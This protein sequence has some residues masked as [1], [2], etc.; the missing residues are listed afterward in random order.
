MPNPIPGSWH[1]HRGHDPHV[2]RRAHGVPH[3]R[4][5]QAAPH[6][7][8]VSGET[9]LATPA[10]LLVDPEVF[11]VR[12]HRRPHTHTAAT[13]SAR[14]KMATTT[15]RT[16]PRSSKTHAKLVEVE[17]QPNFGR[18]A[19]LIAPR[20]RAAAACPRRPRPPWL[21]L[22]R[23]AMR[24]TRARAARTNGAGHSAAAALRHRSLDR[25]RTRTCADVNPVLAMLFCLCE[26]VLAVVCGIAA[27]GVALVFVL[28]LVLV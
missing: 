20:R 21:L 5:A 28:V 26:F 14:T 23:L 18:S 7:N 9:P 8:A 6:R 4:V 25:L 13:A 10:N 16:H 1:V 15:T 17:V 27:F 19:P 2:L 22:A 3:R 12:C 11:K 24:A